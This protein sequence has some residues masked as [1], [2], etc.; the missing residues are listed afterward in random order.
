MCPVCIANI[1]IRGAIRYESTAEPVLM[2]HVA[3]S[4]ANRTC[5]HPTPARVDQMTPALPKFEKYLSMR[6][7]RHAKKSKPSVDSKGAEET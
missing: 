7:R 2:I 5:R 1:A 4:T 6:T 3:S